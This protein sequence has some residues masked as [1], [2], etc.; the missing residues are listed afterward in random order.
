MALLSDL[1]FACKR[2]ELA[3]LRDILNSAARKGKTER[4]IRLALD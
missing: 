2:L 4:Y 1:A 3:A